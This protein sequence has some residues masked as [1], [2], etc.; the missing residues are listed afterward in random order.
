MSLRHRGYPGIR[1]FKDAAQAPGATSFRD[2]AARDRSVS[3]SVVRAGNTVLVPQVNEWLRVEQ[4][5]HKGNDVELHTAQGGWVWPKTATIRVQD[6]LADFQEIERRA[7]GKYIQ[8]DPDEGDFVVTEDPAGESDEYRT[9]PSLQGAR[10]GD[11]RPAEILQDYIEG[12]ITRAECETQLF[13][14][15]VPRETIEKYLRDAD[16]VKSRM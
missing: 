8:R 15:G 3:I 4:V 7:D 12:L 10:I 9:Y 5:V 2:A 16:Y 6:D 14:N 13:N 1:G 11:A